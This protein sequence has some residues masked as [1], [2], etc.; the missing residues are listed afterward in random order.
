MAP[1]KATAVVMANHPHLLEHIRG[2]LAWEF[3]RG[4]VE[5]KLV[6]NLVSS[7]RLMSFYVKP[8]TH[9]EL[10]VAGDSYLDERTMLADDYRKTY[11]IS[12]NAWQ[13]IAEQVEFV[14]EFLPRDTSVM[15][16]QIWPFAPNS[17]SDFAMAVAVALSFT[18]GE[19]MQED[20]ISLAI[21]ELVSQYGFSTDRF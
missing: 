1:I 15:K 10:S 18:P 5:L 9:L 8:F 11:A 20:R 4:P 6:R 7:P 14:E 12:I 2:A 16:L 21:D 19:L 17:L 13:G 3:E